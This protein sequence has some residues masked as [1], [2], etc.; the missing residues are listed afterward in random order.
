MPKESA[1]KSDQDKRW[2]LRIQHT[3][4]GP[5]SSAK[6]RR[7][8]L[9][10]EVTLTDEISGDGR[11]WQRLRDVSEV[12]P[13]NLRAEMGDRSALS[14][15]HSRRSGS[16]G[17]RERFP[18]L[19]SFISLLLLLAIVGAAVWLDRPGESDQP[20]C[21]AP[22]APGV[23]W[24]NCVMSGLDV[25]SASLA[26]AN[27]NSAVLHQARLTAT[28]LSG[29]D[30]RYADL[31]EA[32]LSYAQLQ[33]SVMQGTNLRGANL[34]Q[35]NLSGADLRY[36]DFTGSRLEGVNL[37]AARFGGAIWT[38]GKVCAESSIGRCQFNR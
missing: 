23:D 7:L 27:L 30:L 18:Y 37:S 8:L 29:A 20:D 4:Q 14:L 28:D 25:G 32:D 26:G 17:K 16:A 2:F 12:V 15:M 3:R 38:D 10:G 24:R 13:L 6:V 11:Q 1:V 36:A 22:A 31:Q 19:A 5:F 35:A 33:R 9:E 21:N 34:L